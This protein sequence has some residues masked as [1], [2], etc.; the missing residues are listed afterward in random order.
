M[1]PVSPKK[2]KKYKYQLCFLTVHFQSDSKELMQ[3]TVSLHGF[4]SNAYVGS[5]YKLRQVEQ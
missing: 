4:N 1:T 3:I 2:R 5:Q